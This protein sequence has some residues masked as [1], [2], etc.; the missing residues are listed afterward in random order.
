MAGIGTRMTVRLPLTLA[1]VD[2]MSVAVGAEN[3]IVPLGYVLESLQPEPGMIKRM[4]G[5]DSLIQV[6]GDYLPV[7]VL[8]ELFGVRNAET[9]FSRGIMVLLEVDGRR[10]AVFV[11]ALIGQHQVVIKSLETNYR[12]VQG[13]AAATIMGDGRVAFILDAVALVSKASADMQAAA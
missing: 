12:K 9:D 4:G 7:L 13:I 1:I 8:H 11:D 10:A 5:R 6:R 3:Y 2:G